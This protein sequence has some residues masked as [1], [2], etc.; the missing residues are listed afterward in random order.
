MKFEMVW[1]PNENEAGVAFSSIS[2]LKKYRLK[3]ENE[4]EV[5]GIVPENAMGLEKLWI[6]DPKYH[7]Y[8]LLE[9]G[10]G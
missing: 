6:H 10:K 9:I 3:R 2:C 1:S 4:E 8:A 5:R 7:R